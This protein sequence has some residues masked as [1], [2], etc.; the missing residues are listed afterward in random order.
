MAAII[1]GIVNCDSLPSPNL[2][3]NSTK[4]TDLKSNDESRRSPRKYLELD[5]L[6]RFESPAVHIAKESSAAEELAD[7]QELAK[8]ARPKKFV[9]RSARVDDGTS[10]AE[11]Q[12]RQRVARQNQNQKKQKPG[13]FWTLFRVTFEV[14]ILPTAGNF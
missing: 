4:T 8:K 3:S 9:K 11:Q 10:K 12:Q 14:G 5:D 7:E 13:F 2:S 6:N 1:L